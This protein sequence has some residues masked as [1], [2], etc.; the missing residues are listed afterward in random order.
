[1]ASFLDTQLLEGAT[2]LAEVSIGYAPMIDRDRRIVATRLTVRPLDAATP[3]DIPRLVEAIVEVRLAET[4]RLCLDAPCDALLPDLLAAE[5]PLNVMVEV[6]GRLA[7]HWVPERWLHA[8][9]ARGHTL[10]LQGAPDQLPPERLACFEYAIEPADDTA[11]PRER[12]SRG[13]ALVRAGVRSVAD[14]QAAFAGGAAAAIGWPLDAP[15]T[16]PRRKVPH[17]LRTIIELI[18]RVDAEDEID[19]LEETL[20]GDPTLAFELLRHLNSAAYGLRTEIGSFRQ[21]IMMLG[22]RKLRRWLAL[23]L[24]AT[25]THA[26]LA[27]LRYAAVRRGLLMAEL[28]RYSG[29]DDFASELFICGAFSLLDRMFG[30]RFADLFKSV[31]VPAAVRDALVEG[32]GPYRPFLDLVEAVEAASP[33]DIRRCAAVLSVGTTEVNR[34]TLRAL[35]TAATI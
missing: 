33:S 22:Y 19:R 25:D 18:D 10:L 27:P 15:R 13:P 31:R 21:A 7:G 6:P 9:H 35:A 32:T 29:D 3:I 4:A 20:R 16:G 14:L 30:E 8:L 26:E 23:L 12:G 28:V 34:A 2:V 24:V 17:E 1:M 11:A 5:A